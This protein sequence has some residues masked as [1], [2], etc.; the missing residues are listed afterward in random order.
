MSN[1]PEKSSGSPETAQQ[2][3]NNKKPLYKKKKIIIP[4]LLI[5]AVILG[6]Y[7]WYQSLLGFVSTDDAY[8]DA[9]KLTI[10]SKMMGRIDSLFA[11]EGDTVKQGEVLVALDSSDMVA[12]RNEIETSLELVK[13]NVK[14]AKVNLEK[15]Q[16]DYARGEKQYS[17]KI[18]PA[19]Q[20]DHIK[21]A[22]QMAEV[23]YGIAKTKIK[24]TAAQ[25]KVI[26][27]NLKNA[28]V[29]APM[30]GVIAKK[31]VLKGDVI[32]PG[33]PVFSIYNLNDIW[34]TA[35][36]EETDFAKIAT[37]DTVQITVDSYPENQFIGLVLQRGSNTAAQFSLIPP[38]NASGN[39]TKVTQRIPIKISIMPVN[40]SV[41]KKDLVLLPGMSVEV[42]IKVD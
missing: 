41:S 16:E 31:W 12:K 5:A 25:L 7:Y 39:F 23:Q 26:E 6:G 3:G 33:Q 20:F 24:T 2:K 34:V 8:I 28:V 21:K 32:Q 42:K 14:L 35:Q 36:V 1:T 19:E 11:D 4:I 27:T 38:N 37:N 30:S 15:A 40:S 17:G 18:I 29:T 13:E 22:L 9:D 10:S